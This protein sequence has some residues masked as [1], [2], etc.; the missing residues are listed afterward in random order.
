MSLPVVTTPEADAQIRDIR[1]SAD[2]A[3]RV[4]FNELGER[5]TVRQF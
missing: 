5:C 2:L 1:P 3:V 4:T